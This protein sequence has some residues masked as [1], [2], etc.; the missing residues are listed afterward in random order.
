MPSRFSSYKQALGFWNAVKLYW[1]VK[2]RA[3]KYVHFSFLKHPVFIRGIKSDEL[4]FG[5]LFVEKQYQLPSE[6]TPT[7]ILDLGANVGYASVYFANKYPN[8]RIL[9]LEPETNNFSV[10]QKNVSPYPNI[11][12]LHAAVWNKA[13][14]LNVVDNGYGEAAFMIDEQPAAD[15]VVVAKVPTFTVDEL[16]AKLGAKTQIDLVKMDVEGAEKEIFEGDVAKWLPFTK[17]LIV[18]THDRYKM[19]TSRALFSAIAQYDFSVELSGENLIF[20][21]NQ[22]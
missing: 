7:T 14:E 16:A 10:A 1:H 8:A 9:A 4:M 22:L 11:Q 3:N 13:G 12:L 19:G 15:A 6:F 20:S 5:Q 18:E 17:M 21:N 2:S